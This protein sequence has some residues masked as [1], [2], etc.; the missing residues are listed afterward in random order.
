VRSQDRFFHPPAAFPVPAQV[1]PQG[2]DPGI[3]K[4]GRQAREEAALLPRDT[5]AVHEDDRLFRDRVRAD[6]RARQA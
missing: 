2:S 4:A 5:A 1:V 6:E 3:A